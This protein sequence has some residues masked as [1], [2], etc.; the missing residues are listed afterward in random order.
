MLCLMCFHCFVSC[1]W[2]CASVLCLLACCVFFVNFFSFCFVVTPGV[3]PGPNI[4]NVIVA[5][6]AEREGGKN[7]NISVLLTP[8]VHLKERKYR[9]NMDTSFDI[10][11][12]REDINKVHYYNPNSSTSISTNTKH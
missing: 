6:E 9:L 2:C 1:C 10:E 3:I 8:N 11:T 12:D 5:I 7:I 4:V